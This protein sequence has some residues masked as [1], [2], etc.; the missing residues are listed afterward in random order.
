MM[1]PS[2]RQ[3]VA[4]MAAVPFLPSAGNAQGRSASISAD[5][6]LDQVL[7]DLR[8]LRTELES[9]PASRKSTL[10]AMESAL[11][12]GAAHLAV[13]YDADCKRALRRAQSRRSSR[14]ALIQEIVQQARERGQD[15][16]TFDSVDNAMSRLDQYGLSGAFREVQQI[17]RRIRLQSPDQVQAASA[18]VQFDY[19]SDLNWMIGLMEAMVSLACAI[20]I[21]EPT[22]GGE[23][24]CGAMTLALGLM[25]LQRMI[26]C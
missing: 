18:R 17:T 26:F 1:I 21:L 20:A 19:C 13:H 25:L 23:I 3:F 8:N 12:I 15:A 4:A 10:R 7:D 5:P 2:R 16:V 11:G 9:Q 14:A 6:V 22:P 24:A